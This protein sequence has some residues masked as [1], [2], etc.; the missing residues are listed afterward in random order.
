MAKKYSSWNK[1]ENH[2]RANKHH[3]AIG[4]SVFDIVGPFV[5]GPFFFNTLRGRSSL[6]WTPFRARA[7]IVRL[8]TTLAFLDDTTNE[9]FLEFNR[10]GRSI[11]DGRGGEAIGD[12]GCDDRSDTDVVLLRRRL[13]FRSSRSSLRPN[14]KS[15]PEGRPIIT[16]ESDRVSLGIGE[17]SATSRGG[18]GMF[19]MNQSWCAIRNSKTSWLSLCWSGESSWSGCDI[20]PGRKITAKSILKNSHTRPGCAWLNNTYWLLSLNSYPTCVQTL[21]TGLRHIKADTDSLGASNEL[22]AWIPVYTRLG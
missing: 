17:S 13:P 19:S 10:L 22:S 14:I 4:I 6:L 11:D 3:S 18:G 16:G 15:S 12:E 20:M 1:N 2:P 9:S 8:R 5:R 21:I 7:G